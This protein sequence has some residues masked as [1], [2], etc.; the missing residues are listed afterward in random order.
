[1]LGRVFLV[2]VL[3]VM[4]SAGAAGNAPQVWTVAGREVLRIRVTVQGM[5]PRERVERFEE[6]LTE[7]LSRV[8]R[9]L[10][11]NDVELKLE[12]NHATITVCGELL[13]TVLPEDA[14]ANRTTV[15]KLARQWLSNLRKSIPLL[16][17]RVNPRGA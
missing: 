10:A 15:E 1:M 3:T 9:P 6:R 4:L 13:V 16:S 12:G 11:V 2:L 8:E 5:T 17:P 7:I 14:A